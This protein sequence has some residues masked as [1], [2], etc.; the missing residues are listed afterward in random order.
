MEDDLHRTDLPALTTDEVQELKGLWKFQVNRAE[1]EEWA[2]QKMR[3]LVFDDT[4]DPKSSESRVQ[5]APEDTDGDSED[6]AKL[7]ERAIALSL[8]TEEDPSAAS[9]A[10]FPGDLPPSQGQEQV[11]CNTCVHIPEFPRN[12]NV[13]SFRLIE[14][15]K[16]QLCRHYVAISY[17]WPV[18]QRDAAGHIIK[19]P[20]RSRVRDLDGAVR[21]SRALDDVLDRAVDF[22]TAAGLRMIWID[23]ECLP[24]PT[25]SSPV[26][27]W[28]YQQ[29]GLQ[30]MD[31]VYYRAFATVGL[32]EAT[33][34]TQE[35]ADIIKGLLGLT[36]RPEPTFEVLEQICQFFQM[37]ADDRWY[38][39]A[40]VVQESMSAGKNLYLALQRGRGVDFPSTFRFEGPFSRRVPSRKED[41]NSLAI[42][43]LQ[44]F[45]DIL[46]LATQASASAEPQ[47]DSNYSTC[48]LGGPNNVL[49]RAEL[50]HPS[51]VT[52]AGSP[53]QVFGANHHGNRQSVNASTA[54]TLLKT[55]DCLM[56]EDKIAILA[57]LCDYEIRLNTTL[58]A[59]HCKS[60]RSAVLAL[61]LFNGDSSIL[62][63]EVFQLQLEPVVTSGAPGHSIFS[64]FDTRPGSIQ[65]TTVLAEGPLL[66]R[67]PDPSRANSAVVGLPVRCH[68]WTVESELDLSAVQAQYESAWDE[69]QSIRIRV[70]PRPG[71]SRVEFSARQQSIALHFQQPEII[72]LAR[73]EIR[74]S[75]YVKSSSRAWHGVDSAGVYCTGG[76]MPQTIEADPVMK[77]TLAGIIF[78]ILAGLNVLGRSDHRAAGVANSIW[79][80]LRVHCLDTSMDLPDLVS[81]ELFVHRHVLMSN[82]RTLRLDQ[83]PD[84]TYLQLWFV[85]RV[86]RHGSL[87]V[88][89]YNRVD[90]L[91]TRAGMGEDGTPRAEGASPEA[92]ACQP[93]NVDQSESATASSPASPR[94]DIDDIA[95][96]PKS[97]LER[98]IQQTLS[99]RLIQSLSPQ[100]EGEDGQTRGY[101][102]R[103]AMVY[104]LDCLSR[105][106]FTP[107]AEDARV[108]DLVSVFD[109]D[110]PC[111]VAIPFN[112]EWETLPHSSLR[113]MSTCWVVE[114][115]STVEPPLGAS[116]ENTEHQPRRAVGS[117]PAVSGE[118]DGS[119][120]KG[121]GKEDTDLLSAPL[122]RETYR[123]VGKVRGLWQMMDFPENVAYFV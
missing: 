34:R 44:E 91:L 66:P 15:G 121:K 59:Q 3:Y 94:T 36:E 53:M 62:V 86:M 93:D 55:R 27:D 105:E 119:D 1:A 40:W 17:C 122:R 14:A 101:A 96:E 21:S 65:D 56:A 123:V 48:T 109:I 58:V 33:L 42:L 76:V 72:R 18:P 79:Q 7:L 30:A 106:V 104:F 51:P 4:A 2:F 29:M 22:A 82:F 63:P 16:G 83:G 98:Q 10:V 52:K 67:L 88:G 61:A 103:A 23:Q 114:Q 68:T 95:G 19:K 73:Q 77:Q 20:S 99:W 113:S 97:L 112:P 26:E 100:T 89:A 57:N 41:N 70:D 71:E 49:E 47:E 24:Q 81:D 87:W 37:I 5:S 92:E 60:L 32:L 111:V 9:P 45:R 8:Q 25:S 6:E 116:P 28:T 90:S 35:Q 80:S 43:R 46:A 54:L 85:E 50:L 118:N 74:E 78:G 117:G 39:R 64:P 108:R 110:G 107:Q 115:L 102:S 38:T 31:I 120:D 13:R 11:P 84:G 12:K 69:L 75:G